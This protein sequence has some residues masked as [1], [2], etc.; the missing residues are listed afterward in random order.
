MW[1]FYRAT[2]YIDCGYEALHMGQVHLYTANDRGMRK[3]WELFGMIRQYATEHARRHKV[4][5]DAHTHGINIRGKLL[6]DYHAMPVSRVALL[7]DEGTRLVL[8]REG[9]SVG[10]ENVN[11]FSGDAMPYLLEFDNWGGKVRHMTEGMTRAE[12][13]RTDWWGYDQIGWFANQPKKERDRF[14]HYTW[15]WTQVNNPNAYFLLPFRRMLSDAAVTMRRADNEQLD[16]QRFYQMNDPSPGCPMG[17]GQENA[18]EAC[19]KEGD[20]LRKHFANPSGLINYGARDEYDPETGLKLP[21]KVV[22]YGTFQPY[23]GATINDSNSELTRMYYVGD[24]TY[25]LTVVM[26]YAGTFTYAVSTYGTLSAVFAGDCYP[27]SGSKHHASF[28]VAQDNSV[29]RFTYHFLDNDVYVEV[30][31][32][33]SSAQDVLSKAS[34]EAILMS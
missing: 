28:T 19:W 25:T 21:E 14:L 31:D 26:P 23:V 16:T 8:V 18:A 15:R 24:N 5:L 34:D 22:V 30:A 11:G 17:F 2:R 33:P 3:T 32:L 1:F 27:R 13:A 9:F 29:V 10:G 6:F 4:L 20:S 7:E 12:L